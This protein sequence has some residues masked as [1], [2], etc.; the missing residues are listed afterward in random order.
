[1]MFMN[2]EPNAGHMAL[3]KLEREGVLQAVVTQ[4]IDGLHQLA[5]SKRVYELH[6]SFTTE[7]RSKLHY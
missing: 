5:G 4:N 2:A 3:A 6:G 1:M 7:I